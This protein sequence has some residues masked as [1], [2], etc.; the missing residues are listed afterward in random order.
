MA[1]EQLRDAIAARPAGAH[2]LRVCPGGAG[3]FGPVLPEEWM[4]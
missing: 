3:R 4:P 1:F 2:A